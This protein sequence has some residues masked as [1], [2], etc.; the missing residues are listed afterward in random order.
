M[1]FGF[2]I[3]HNPLVGGSSPPG[4][5]IYFKECSL[6][7]DLPDKISRNIVGRIW[8][9]GWNEFRNDRVEILETINAAMSNSFF[10]LSMLQ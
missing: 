10:K 8:L 6:Q 9:P 1:A 4:P 7:A 2:H 5:T 3:T